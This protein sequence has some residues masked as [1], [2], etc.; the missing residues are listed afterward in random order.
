MY[1]RGRVGTAWLLILVQLYA[2]QTAI[3]PDKQLT[4]HA[5]IHVSINRCS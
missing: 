4:R 2:L 5:H 3:V 1:A